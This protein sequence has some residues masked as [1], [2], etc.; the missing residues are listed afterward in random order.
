[1]SVDI[2]QLVAIEL[3]DEPRPESSAGKV[4]KN[5]LR[6]RFWAGHGRRAR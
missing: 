2:D 6:E 3:R 4:L 5:V 1:M